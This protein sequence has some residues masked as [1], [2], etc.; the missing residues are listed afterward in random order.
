MPCGVFSSDASG[1]CMQCDRSQRKISL[2]RACRPAPSSNC[3]TF[4]ASGNCSS[5]KPFFSLSGS[6][7]VP[8]PEC[9]FPSAD[10]SGCASCGPGRLYT[11]FGV[12]GP[13]KSN[14]LEIKQPDSSEERNCIF[15]TRNLQCSVCMP[16][17]YPMQWKRP[18]ATS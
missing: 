8:N 9:R 18:V 13:S 5:C 10:G 4:D 14:C 7:C 6:T 2:T 1:G 17:F 16:G 12:Q 11:Y 15:K 3:Q